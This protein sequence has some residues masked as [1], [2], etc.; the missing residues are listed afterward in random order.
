[1]AARRP[2]VFDSDGAARCD[3]LRGVTEVLRWPRP[4]AW[5]DFQYQSYK[6]RHTN[7]TGSP[8]KYVQP[9]QDWIGIPKKV[10]DTQ[11]QI[12][13]IDENYQNAR[14]SVHDTLL[15]LFSLRNRL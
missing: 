14:D 1:M 8:A 9:N 10:V 7:E 13:E 2:E 11:V 15:Q 5:F 3:R 6:Q 12:K 4:R